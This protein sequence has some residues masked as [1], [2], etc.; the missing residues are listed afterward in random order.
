MIN[1]LN[2]KEENN[3]SKEAAKYLLENIQLEN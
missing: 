1:I 2:I 3:T